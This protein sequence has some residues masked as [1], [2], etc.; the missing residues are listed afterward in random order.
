MGLQTENQ[1][2][3]HCPVLSYLILFY[4]GFTIKM[5][6]KVSIDYRLGEAVLNLPGS[7]EHL[8]SHTVIAS[9]FVS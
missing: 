4:G 2:F 6:Y 7:R 8:P 1:N 5:K 9:S 3:N